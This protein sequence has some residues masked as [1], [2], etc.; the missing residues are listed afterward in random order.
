MK[1]VLR[2]STKEMPTDEIKELITTLNAVITEKLEENKRA[3]GKKKKS[4]KFFIYF[5]CLVFVCLIY[6]Y[7]YNRTR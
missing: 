1:E 2:I 4:N 6:M 7:I 5:H 3:A